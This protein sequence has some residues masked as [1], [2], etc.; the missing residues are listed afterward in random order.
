M[1]F[2]VTRHYPPVFTGKKK[3]QQKH[4]TEAKTKYKAEKSRKT[5]LSG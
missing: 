3:A 1:L 4:V 2:I 5:K